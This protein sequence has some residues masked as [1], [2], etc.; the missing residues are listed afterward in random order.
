MNQRTMLYRSMLINIPRKEETITFFHVKT[1]SI[2][3]F[4]RRLSRYFLHCFERASSFPVTHL[5]S[6]VTARN[7]IS[8]TKLAGFLLSTKLAPLHNGTS[9][10]HD[11]SYA[12][13]LKCH[14]AFYLK[15]FTRPAGF[16]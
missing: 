3:M 6:T 1:N 9:D 11:K 5:V 13:Q 14:F 8:Y 10:F 12:T 4:H 15:C 16:T 2:V 7:E